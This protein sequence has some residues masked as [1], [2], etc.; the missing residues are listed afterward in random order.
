M[1]NNELFAELL[2]IYRENKLAHAYLFETN[3]VDKCYQDIKSLIKK[4]IC[5]N[6]YEDSCVKCELCHQVDDNSL[7]SIISI[8]PDG[9]SIKKDVIEN[10]KKAFS[11][12]PTY[13]PFNIYIMKYPEKMNATAFNKML[14]FLEEP[15]E[16]IIGFY[17]SENKD[18]VAS[19]IVSR[20]EVVK[21]YYDNDANN[22]FSLDNETYQMV[23]AIKDEYFQKLEKNSPDINWYNCTVILK[24]LPS[25]EQIVCLLKLIYNTYEQFFH[26]SK[27]TITLKKLKIVSKYL[28]MLNYNVNTALLLDSFVIEMGEVNGK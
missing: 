17:I 25:Q 22:N 26:E 4:M 24:K 19:T 14:K 20:C 6:S 27:N 12:K 7:P 1:K 11:L 21:S 9:K 2:E 10:L 15:E 5:Q 23:L 3:N 13:T 8:E 18:N 28:E 16:D